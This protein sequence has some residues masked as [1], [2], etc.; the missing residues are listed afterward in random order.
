[1][2]MEGWK[3]H[4]PSVTAIMLAISL[5]HHPALDGQVGELIQL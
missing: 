1:M 4:P 5:C 3:D 2:R